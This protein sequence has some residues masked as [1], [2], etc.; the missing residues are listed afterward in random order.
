MPRPSVAGGCTVGGGGVRP[1][2]VGPIVVK[3]MRICTICTTTVTNMEDATAA[4]A[5]PTVNDDGAGVAL[6]S[7][8]PDASPK[9][10]TDGAAAAELSLPRADEVNHKLPKFSTRAQHFFHRPNGPAEIQ[11]TGVSLV[12]MGVS[13][14]LNVG[15]LFRLLACFGGIGLTHV[16]SIRTKEKR[17]HETPEAAGGRT[18]AVGDGGE[19]DAEATITTTV[20]GAVNDGA[21]AVPVAAITAAPKREPPGFS[22]GQSFW[23][24]PEIKRKVG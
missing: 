10:S 14:P 11:A 8:Q 9:H 22:A 1:F 3:S 24:R 16:H 6:E 17:T 18:A 19:H 13:D 15:S 7:E 12:A 20:Q 23:K 5:N 21:A 4:A 2:H